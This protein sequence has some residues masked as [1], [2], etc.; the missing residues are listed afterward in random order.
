VNTL[1]HLQ[2]INTSQTN[3]RQ[4]LPTSTSRLRSSAR[5]LSHGHIATYTDRTIQMA[6]LGLHTTFSGSIVYFVEFFRLSWFGGATNT[7][8]ID[9]FYSIRQVCPAAVAA[10][11]YLCNDMRYYWLTSYR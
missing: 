9:A 3:L 5:D 11:C 1:V 4:P 7:C 6:V 10:W 2:I 8:S